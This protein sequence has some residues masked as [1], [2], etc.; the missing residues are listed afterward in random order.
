MYNSITNI[1][2]EQDITKIDVK[3]TATERGKTFIKI[4]DKMDVITT[5]KDQD[6]T[7][8]K[9]EEKMDVKNT[10]KKQD[11]IV[12]KIEDENLCNTKSHYYIQNLFVLP[13]S[14]RH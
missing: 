12:I 7:V 10:A 2:L 14:L 4:E 8:I 5:A 11:K 6:K 13:I 9:I 3:T 1:K